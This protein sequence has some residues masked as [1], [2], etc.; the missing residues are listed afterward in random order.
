[1]GIFV[2]VV[3]DG[4]AF[5]MLSFLE[6][7]GEFYPSRYAKFFDRWF[8]ELQWWELLK[9]AQAN[10]GWVCLTRVPIF[11]WHEIFFTQMESEMGTLVDISPMTLEHKDLCK[12]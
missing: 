10:R 12:A 11:L 6:R 2:R 3:K 7:D 9:L 4:V 8:V 1:M 5:Y